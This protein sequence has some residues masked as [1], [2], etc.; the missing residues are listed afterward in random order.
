M[1]SGTTYVDVPNWA[2]ANGK[3][4]RFVRAI[5]D[6]RRWLGCLMRICVEEPFGEHP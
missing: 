4:A 5:S 1:P 2:L 6:G 3:S